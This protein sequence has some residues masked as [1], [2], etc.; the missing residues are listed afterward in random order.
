MGRQPV[1][2]HEHTVWEEHV[3]ERGRH[4]QPVVRI[5]GHHLPLWVLSMPQPPK[6]GGFGG[7]G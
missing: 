1:M 6:L 2:N 4:A 5:T 7:G 3:S